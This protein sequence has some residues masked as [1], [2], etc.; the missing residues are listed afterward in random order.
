MILLVNRAD[1]QISKE[2]IMLIPRL[3]RTILFK[4]K[5]CLLLALLCFSSL[6]FAYEN[7]NR[8]SFY[9]DLSE[10]NSLAGLDWMMELSK[11]EDLGCIELSGE[12]SHLSRLKV[13]WSDDFDADLSSQHYRYYLSL[14]RPQT[15]LRL[16]LQRLNFGSA[17]VLRPLMWFDNIDPMD[18]HQETK[19]VEALLLRHH[20]LNSANLWFWGIRGAENPKGNEFIGGKKNSL[21]FGGRLQYPSLIG[22]A[23]ICYHQRELNAGHEY[24]LGMDLRMDYAIGMWLEASASYF[25]GEQQPVNYSAL[26]SIGVDYVLEIG[27]GLAITSEGMLNALSYDALSK[28]S[29]NDFTIAAMA[30]YPLGL[31]DS[32][33]L[34]TSHTFK[35]EE[36]MIASSWRRTYDLLSFEIGLMKAKSRGSSINLIISSVF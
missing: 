15:E 26:A 36:Y 1:I 18:S 5:T 14:N 28:I 2:K 17:K 29:Y 34:L 10:N 11:S 4:A 24:R 20:W 23:G 22:D 3:N 16:G 32:L 12:Y 35:R 19:G 31:L 21:E 25:D 8:L 27:N 13:S 7:K 9:A 6:V 30:D 33:R